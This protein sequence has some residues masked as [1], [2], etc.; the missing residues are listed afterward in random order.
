M[1]PTDQRQRYRQIANRA[2]QIPGVHGLRPWR[3]F[4]SVGTWSGGATHFGNGTRSD[5]EV[6]LLE[7]GQ[8][9]K[10]RQVKAE[11]VAL[12]AGLQSGDWTIGPVTPIV[13]T[14]WATMSGGGIL[15]SDSFAIRMTNEET[16]ED[17]RCV[18]VSSTSDRALRTMLTVR[19]VRG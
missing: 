8:P 3:V 13:G 17:L 6:E 5:A 10:V 14:P 9:P 1:S 15:D 19:P 11:Q 2:R 16:G 7:S 12:D 4:A 18:L